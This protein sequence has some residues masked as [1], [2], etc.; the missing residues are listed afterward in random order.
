MM[1][2]IEEVARAICSAQMIS[3]Q[4]T[5]LDERGLLM[6]LEDCVNIAWPLYRGH[7]V[8]ALR[9]MCTPTLEMFQAA[10]IAVKATDVSL[11]SGFAWGNGWSAAIMK[12]LE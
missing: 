11:G 9:A 10:D 2:K 5:A 1:G 8:L 4:T 7:A 12:A 3:S 6:P